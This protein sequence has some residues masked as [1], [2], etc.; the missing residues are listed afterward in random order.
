MATP[1]IHGSLRIKLLRLIL[2]ALLLLGGATL[3]SI[4]ALIY[5]ADREVQ[6]KRE[7]ELLASLEEKARLLGF[8]QALALRSLVADNLFGDV[9]ALIYQTVSENNDIAYGLF[10]DAEGRVWAASG[11]GPASTAKDAPPLTAKDLQALGISA[12]HSPRPVLR[13]RANP[14]GGDDVLEVAAPVVS[15]GAHAGTV[16]YGIST[17]G[18]VERMVQARSLAAAPRDAATKTRREQAHALAE[19]AL[20]A[21]RLVPGHAAQI[22]TITGW[23]RTLAKP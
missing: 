9:K 13:R 11:L 4:G 17:R 10:F 3:L 8:N 16:I 22:A 12:E 19:A 1:N 18:V 2:G 6:A 15:E 7:Q 21:E 14:M 5:S 23:M 20:A